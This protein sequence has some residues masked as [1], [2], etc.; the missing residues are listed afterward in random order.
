[1]YERN[2]TVVLNETGPPRRPRPAKREAAE[3]GQRCKE[4]TITAAR[5]RSHTTPWWLWWNILSFDAPTVAVVWALLLARPSHIRLRA[6]DEIVLSLVVWCIYVSDRLFDGL[7]P[8]NQ[9]VLR[10][11]HLFCAK[12]RRA[13]TWLFVLAAVAVLWVTA[14]FLA[15]TEVSAGMKLAA[16]IG[17]YMA[18]IHAGHGSMARFVPKEVAVGIL[19]AVG[20]T[21]PAWSRLSEFS[22]DE[23]IPFGLFAVLCSLN[24]LAIE[25]WENEPR[26]P[27]WFQSRSPVIRWAETRINQLAV[28]LA[29]P[30]FAIILVR[31]HPGHPGPFGFGLLAISLEALLILLLNRHRNRLSGRALRV[32][33]DATLVL[34]GGLAL[35]T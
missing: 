5:A 22:W 1:M 29:A 9:R 27:D 24:C 10:E 31:R 19:F 20:T 8:T 3:F 16:I 18:S 35:V 6:A 33:A 14:D 12:H 28:A 2:D 32:L 30:A 21:L 26:Y 13:L 15:P 23:W 17:A 34:S 7:K 25:C 4:P 11:R